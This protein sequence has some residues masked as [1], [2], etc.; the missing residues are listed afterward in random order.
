MNILF[1]S[2][3]A[4]YDSVRHAGGKTCNY[5]I[6]SFNQMEDVSVWCVCMYREPDEGR[7]DFKNY[8]IDYRALKTERYTELE[9]IIH[10]VIHPFDKYANKI[11]QI[12]RENLLNSI[13]RFVDEGHRPDAVI[14][15]WT[16]ISLLISD[17]KKIL[18]QCVFVASEHD[19]SFQG[20]FR[21]IKTTKN[22]VRKVAQYWQ[23]NLLK[24]REL[25]ALKQF[26][27]ICPHNVKDKD[28]LVD[29]GLSV[30]KIHPIVPYYTDYSDV[31]RTCENKDIIFFGAM[32]RE[33][34]YLSAIWFIE[35]VFNRYNLKEQK[36][37]FVVI[38]NHP[39]VCLKKYENEDI[40]ITGFVSDDELKRY[41][42]ASKCFVA[43]LVLGSGIKVK[44]LE[45]F[46]SGIPVLTNKIG[47]EGIGGVHGEQYLHCETPEDYISSLKL[48]ENKDL[49]C[50][51]GENGKQYVIDEFDL[52]A[53]SNEYINRIRDLL[54]H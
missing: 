15:E 32:E 39:N 37:R 25:E 10:G 3:E 44:I 50:K 31:V 51:I 17:L 2:Y 47:I 35:N 9:R 36:Y 7:L 49:A 28:L 27:M 11:Q 23:Y 20:S 6:K 40:I 29:S 45:A 4:P 33:A 18:P 26:D 24:K 54:N 8:C 5:Y 22:V 41:F 42:S 52:K 12:D 13:S 43:P 16:T 46:S 30:E 1:I 48:L 14:C 38:G 34:N 19:V 53:S 21:L